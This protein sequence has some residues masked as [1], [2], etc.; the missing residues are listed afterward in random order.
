MQP[1]SYIKPVTD[2]AETTA[3]DAEARRLRYAGKVAED[4]IQNV[5]GAGR[6]MDL[7][8]PHGGALEL[9]QADRK[10]YQSMEQ[11]GQD[12][13]NIASIPFDETMGWLLN[14]FSDDYVPN[15]MLEARES[16]AQESL[17][18]AIEHPIT[19]LLPFI[20][21][22]VARYF[23]PQMAI[24]AAVNDGR[25][26]EAAM[27]IAKAGVEGDAMTTAVLSED[28]LNTSVAAKEFRTLKTFDESVRKKEYQAI[29]E[30]RH[31]L[32]EKGWNRDWPFT[33]GDL[34]NKAFLEAIKNDPMLSEIER[35]KIL[36]FAPGGINELK[37]MPEMVPDEKT[38]WYTGVA[39]GSEVISPQIKRTAYTQGNFNP[40]PPKPSV[41]KMPPE[42]KKAAD[43]SGIVDKAIRDTHAETHPL[44]PQPAPVAPEPVGPVEVGPTPD[45]IFDAY[46]KRSA[47]TGYD[48]MYKKRAIPVQQK[49]VP[50]PE[51]EYDPDYLI[52]DRVS[53]PAPDASKTHPIVIKWR[54]AKARNSAAAIKDIKKLEKEGYFIGDAEEALDEYRNTVR[55]DFEDAEEYSIAR[56]E[57]WDSFIEALDGL[58][59]P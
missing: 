51:M 33:P 54:N 47:A 4:L 1:G 14:T 21:P 46:M 19:Y 45:A 2:V 43:Y 49:P 18:R 55:A 48:P 20:A 11:M 23:A 56:E 15:P 58:E 9:A 50:A 5:G 25:V 7:G 52:S 44:P 6:I 39:G 30:S 40:E 8:Q 10:M 16:S 26:A 27:G 32:I 35:S 22:I 24:E 12:Y 13:L 36:S 38:S 3:T 59:K 28:Y 53:A 42:V 41:E 37:P 57:A 17:K 34:R 31:G 29:A